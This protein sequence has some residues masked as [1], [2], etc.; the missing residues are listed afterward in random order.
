MTDQ[1]WFKE[2]IRK[3][4]PLDAALNDARIEYRKLED[5][6]RR[7]ILKQR[8]VADVMWD[9]DKRINAIN[10]AAINNPTKG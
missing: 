10:I 1:Q 7:I 5:E 6:E 9:L 3:R 4:E 8:E 2:Q